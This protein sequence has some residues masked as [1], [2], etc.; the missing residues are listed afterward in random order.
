MQKKCSKCGEIKEGNDFFKARINKDGLYSSCKKCKNETTKKWEMANY[1]RVHKAWSKRHKELRLNNIEK[2]REIS[3]R[4]SA[5]LR[6]TAK[7]RLNN[8]MGAGIYASISKGSKGHRHWEDLV[9]YTRE[10]LKIHLEKQFT[11]GMTWENYG[12]WHIDHKIPVSVFNYSCPDDLDFK[13]CWSLKNLRPLWATENERKGTR[14]NEQFQ[15]S[16]KI[17]I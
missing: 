8:S 10:Q 1:E 16:L 17:A 14:I 7:G 9:G 3:R 6:A 13:R 2:A 5:R 4:K 15:P 12:E 11:T